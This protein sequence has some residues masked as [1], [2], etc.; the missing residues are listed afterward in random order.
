MEH[1]FWIVAAII[2]ASFITWRIIDFFIGLLIPTD[3]EIEE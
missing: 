1:N 3:E 2:A